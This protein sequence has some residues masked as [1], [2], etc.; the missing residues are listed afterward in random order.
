M[1]VIWLILAFRI[2]SI[3]NPFV[4]LTQGKTENWSNLGASNIL[5]VPIVAIS[6]PGNV[7]NALTFD[8]LAKTLYLVVIQFLGCYCRFFSIEFWFLGSPMLILALLSSNISY[9]TIGIQYS[10]FLVGP[11]TFAGIIMIS[12]TVNNTKLRK[13]F[14]KRKIK[15]RTIMVG[16][17]L[18]GLILSNPFLS[19]NISNR[20]FA[21]FGIPVLTDTALAVENLLP[22]IPSNA[23]V[24]TDSNIFPL[25]SSRINAYTLPFQIDRN[26]ITFFNYIDG[27]ISK[28][29]YILIT[30]DYWQPWPSFTAVILSRTQSFGVIGYQDGVLVL[31]RGYEG[32][33]LFFKSS[34]M[35]YNYLNL[36]NQTGS[37]VLMILHNLPWF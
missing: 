8:G 17:V 13:I 16:F 32:N 37:I 9:Y 5:Q 3:F 22:L 11:M 29:D 35:S 30:A 20:P 6:N 18:L 28:V 4:P 1:S 12:K 2:I 19:L 31:E 23:S 33:P 10:A 25:V 26:N 34:T 21:G 14:A 24:L 27:I 7:L 36:I 15:G